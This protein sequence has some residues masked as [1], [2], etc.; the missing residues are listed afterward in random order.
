MFFVVMSVA[1]T[2]HHGDRKTVSGG[3]ASLYIMG[4][5]VPGSRLGHRLSWNRCFVVSSASSL[6]YRDSVFK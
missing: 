6:A 2:L 1:Q 4:G 5:E 3:N